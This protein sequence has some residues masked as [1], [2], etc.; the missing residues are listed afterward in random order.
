MWS[1]GMWFTG[2]LAGLMIGL[3]SLRDPFQP[4]RLYVSMNINYLHT[5]KFHWLLFAE[6]ELDD[7]WPCHTEV[8]TCCMCQS[9]INFMT[10]F[11][12]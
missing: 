6:Q 7:L 1:L 4:K 9:K 8:V 10:V 2:D 5:K 11:K 3:D 12:Y